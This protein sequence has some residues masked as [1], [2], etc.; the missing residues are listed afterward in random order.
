MR[1]SSTQVWPSNPSAHTEWRRRHSYLS[2]PLSLRWGAHDSFVELMRG[3]GVQWGGAMCEYKYLG[4]A[5]KA[6][7]TA[8]VIPGRFLFSL[9]PRQRKEPS[10]MGPRVGGRRLGACTH[11]APSGRG[12]PVIG[13]WQWARAWCAGRP[14]CKMGQGGEFRPKQRFFLFLISIPFF[15]LK[16]DFKITTNLGWICTVCIKCTTRNPS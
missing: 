2:L 7:A 16:F 13:Y 1:S 4:D 12:R 8:S 5:A 15:K 14:G 3:H 6:V 11:E 9:S 10:L